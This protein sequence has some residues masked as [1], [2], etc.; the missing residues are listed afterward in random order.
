[1]LRHFL[2]LDATR[3]RVGSDAPTIEIEAESSAQ[4]R[5]DSGEIESLVTNLLS[6]AIRHTPRTGNRNANLALCFG[7]RRPSSKRYR[8]RYCRGTYSAVDRAV[9]SGRSRPGAGGWWR[10]ARAGN[11]QARPRPPRSRTSRIERHPTRA[12]NFA[13]ISRPNESLSQKCN[14]SVMEATHSDGNLRLT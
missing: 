12:V 13:V 10:R 2:S 7:R 9:L 11:R 14:I 4:L 1:M 8:G 6:N 3:F 5:G